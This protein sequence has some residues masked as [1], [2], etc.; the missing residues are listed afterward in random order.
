MRFPSPKKTPFLVR[1]FFLLIFMPFFFV[2]PY[3]AATNNPNENT[4]TFM[5]MAIVEDHTFQLDKIVARQGWTNDMARVKGRDGAM[6]WHCVKGPGTGYLGVP[7]Y[8][9]YTKIGPLLGTPMPT[10]TSPYEQRIQWFRMTTWVLRI[11]SVQLPCF[12]FLVWFERYLRG[13]SRDPVLRLTCVAA[14]G[15]GTNYLAYANMY[16]SH[17]TFAVATFLA[18]GIVERAYREQPEPK[19]RGWIAAFFGGLT[20]GWITMLEYH[21]LPMSIAIAIFGFCVFH[22]PTRLLAYCFGGLITIGLEMLYQWRSFGNPLT[23]GHQFVENP[24]WAV[25]HKQGLFGTVMPNAERFAGLSLPVG[26]GFFGLSPFMW[27]GFL[28]IPLVFTLMWRSERKLRVLALSTVVW[29][30]VMALLW[31]AAAGAIEWR[32]GWTLGPRRL[33]AAPPFFAFGALLALEWFAEKGRFHRAATRGLASGLALSGVFA[34]GLVG[35]VY[36]TLPETQLRP[37][38]YFA[39]PLIQGGFVSHHIGE[40]FGWK[41]VT[42]WYIAAAG[43]ILAPIIVGLWRAKDRGSMY[44]MRVT[45]ML[46]A[47]AVA[48]YPQFTTPAPEE[49]G[50]HAPTGQNWASGWEPAG[51]DRL[52]TL[53]NEA[54]RYGKR[55]PCAWY[56]LA[57]LERHL[58]MDLMALQDEKKAGAPR[59]ETCK[60]LPF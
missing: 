40:W 35:I 42:L 56:R 51:R 26:S 50:D 60:S 11:F 16:A 18:Y 12:L 44:A 39:M 38:H 41:D 10:E 36:N 57:D 46:L 4:R 55:R 47:L 58:H 9:A 54:E 29:T 6:H 23:P 13:I 28:A 43:L 2:F 27:L 34:V 3:F 24:T 52:S 59:D 25:E 31:T 32:A 15:L 30:I 45:M 33:G 19:K 20:A 5:T 21:G 53:R 8:W 14:A 7:V 1:L 17:A 48:I 49:I 37:L 22:R